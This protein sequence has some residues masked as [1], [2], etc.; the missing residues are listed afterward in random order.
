MCLHTYGLS[1]GKELH[2]PIPWNALLPLIKGATITLLYWV[3]NP[4]ILPWQSLQFACESYMRRIYIY[5]YIFSRVKLLGVLS[6]SL[7]CLCCFCFGISL[8]IE[9]FSLSG[10]GL[11]TRVPSLFL[12]RGG[13]DTQNWAAYLSSLTLLLCWAAGINL[14]MLFACSHTLYCQWRLGGF[15]HMLRL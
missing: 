15:R 9:L 12:T 5:I 10:S 1:G 2:M 6:H 14:K 8:C 4:T 3:I 13:E 11:S 7:Q